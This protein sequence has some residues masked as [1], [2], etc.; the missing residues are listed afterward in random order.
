MAA[1]SRC[2][3]SVRPAFQYPNC[4]RNAFKLFFADAHFGGCYRCV[5]APYAAQ[6]H[7]PKGRSRP[8]AARLRLFLG[9][10]PDDTKAPAKQPLMFRR[11]YTRF[12]NR[13]RKLE[14]SP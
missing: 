1:D 4:R 14:E 7:S 3:E 5:D 6:Q 10:S 11:T 2:L 12:L 8:Q 13:L 9:S